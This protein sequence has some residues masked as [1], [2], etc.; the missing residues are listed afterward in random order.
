MNEVTL[1]VPGYD[2]QRGV[3]APAEGGSIVVEVRDGAVEIFGDSAGLR[4]LARWCLALSDSTA[5]P[6]A[7]VHLDPGV[8]PLSL[9]SSPLM[10]ARVRG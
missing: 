6:G 9:E 2:S 8:M 7:H 1:S 5:P 10:L 4:D 3:I